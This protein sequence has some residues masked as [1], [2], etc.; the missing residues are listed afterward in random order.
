M[1][2]VQ[3][4]R[5]DV[6]LRAAM[7]NDETYSHATS[8]IWQLA[9]YDTLHGG[10]RYAN[11][12]GIHLL[13]HLGRAACLTSASHVLEL[14]CGV[15]DI[16]R[17][18][19]DRFG[20]HVTGVELNRRQLEHARAHPHPLVEF[21]EADVRSF[22]TSSRFDAIAAF[23]SL[24]LVPSLDVVL[25][26]SASML[27]PGGTL[28]LSDIVAGPHV[29]PELQRY[30]WEVDAVVNLPTSNEYGERL[31][32]AGLRWIEIADLTHVAEA[33][34]DAIG[35]SL[36]GYEEQLV[37]ECGAA[38]VEEWR[39]AV[40]RYAGAFARRELLYVCITARHP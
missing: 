4:D 19:A 39:D 25:R 40:A 24:S 26:N 20:C 14:C 15:G 6:E 9:V 22:H 3:K 13:E 1:E 32:A 12:G 21:I 35:V 28:V 2:T 23:D 29:T 16:C 34:F 18:L 37:R 30:M 8:A 33:S 36:R 27:A 31:T 5:E 7:Q 17:D 38:D 10:R 11:I